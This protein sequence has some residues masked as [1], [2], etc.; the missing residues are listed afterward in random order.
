MEELFGETDPDWSQR[1]DYFAQDE[2][3]VHGELNQKTRLM[4]ILAASIA[5]PAPRIF[6]MLLE[7][8]MDNEIMPAEIKEVVYQNILMWTLVERFRFCSVPISF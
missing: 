5:L 1:F 4:V 8:A 2:A 7:M 3:T 6:H